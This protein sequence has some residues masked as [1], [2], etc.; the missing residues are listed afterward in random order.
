MS[1]VEAVA[2]VIIALTRSDERTGV[3]SFTNAQSGQSADM[4]QYE[5]ILYRIANRSVF[6]E[7][8]VKYR[9]KS[10]IAVGN[11]ILLSLNRALLLTPY[12]PRVVKFRLYPILIHALLILFVCLL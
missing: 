10:V 11:C 9:T 4:F 1:I 2:P 7:V 6:N 3:I 8:T 5:I 12:L